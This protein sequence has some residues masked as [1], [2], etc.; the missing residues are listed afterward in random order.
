MAVVEKRRSVRPG[1]RRFAIAV[2]IILLP[3]ALHT[4]WDY[5][6]ARRLARIISDI[7]ARNEP[8]ASV[9]DVGS[10]LLTS[11]ENAARYYEAAAAL[12]YAEPL[13]GITGLQHRVAYASDDD[14]DEVV[15]EIRT[16]LGH[17]TE[18]EEFL[19]RATALTFEGYPPGTSYSYRADRLFK[20]ARLAN[21]RALERLEARDAERAADAIIQQL[22]INRPLGAS[23]QP[24]FPIIRNSYFTATVP[25]F[26]VPR[27]LEVMPS[28]TA[29][30][31]V[32]TAIREID[33]DNAIERSLSERFISERSGTN[34]E[35]G[36]SVRPVTRRA[37]HS[38]T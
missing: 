28:D 35:V 17:N 27:L 22:R 19:A 5:Y 26:D 1:F 32:Q 37:I 24:G 7:K 34:R 36:T 31:R 9:S 15:K 11:P 16:W 33:D 3:I 2:F 21:Y 38:G 23:G 14:R 30:Q 12:I 29:L 13:Y 25:L 4:A 18:A 20:L 6:Q 8:T 10:A